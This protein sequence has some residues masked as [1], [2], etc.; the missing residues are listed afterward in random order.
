MADITVKVLE[1]AESF[2]LISLAEAKIYL[3]ISSADTTSDAQLQM[4]ID[5]NSATIA[6]LCN[7]TFA[8]EKVRE[9]WRCIMPLTC[10]DGAVKIHLMRW[11]VLET[12]VD[13]VESPAGTVLDP[14][15]YEI[16]EDSGKLTLFTG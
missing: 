5:M 12:D 4:L 6:E 16:E 15:E 10:P 13:S 14:L 1:P 9:T 7:R 11:P 8:K 3:G 2:A